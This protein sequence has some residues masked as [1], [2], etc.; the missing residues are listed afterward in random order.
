MIK[1]CVVLEGKVI[2]IGEWDDLDGTNPMPEGAVVEEREFE[3]TEEYGWREVGYVEPPT[4][5]DYLTDYL[6]DVDF[7]LILVEMGL[8]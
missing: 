3:Y 6:L 1:P 4:E 5:I 2:N 7:R 8:V